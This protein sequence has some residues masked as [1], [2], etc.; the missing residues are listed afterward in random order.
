M[1]R[2]PQNSNDVD[3]NIERVEGELHAKFRGGVLPW[4]WWFPKFRGVIRALDHTIW[5]HLRPTFIKGMGRD[6][7]F[8]DVELYEGGRD[9]GFWDVEHY[10]GVGR[11]QG[12]RV[13]ELCAAGAIGIE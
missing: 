11:D 8:W 2:K 3:S 4:R 1:G 10:E 5:L 13:P 6:Q 12:F 7:G 9:Q